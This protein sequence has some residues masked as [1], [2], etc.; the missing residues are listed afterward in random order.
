MGQNII[1]EGEVA[2]PRLFLCALCEHGCQPAAADLVIFRRQFH[3]DIAPTRSDAGLAHAA[4]AHEWIKDSGLRSCHGQQIFNQGYGFAGQVEL[5]CGNY[6]I[7][8]H[9]R[10]A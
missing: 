4:A 7:G 2:G 8:V 6:R 1:A 3:A 10:Q 5:S 9:A